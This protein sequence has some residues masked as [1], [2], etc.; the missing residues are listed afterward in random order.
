LLST[1]DSNK[2]KKVQG[3]LVH[4]GL[5]QQHQFATPREAADSVLQDVHDAKYMGELTTTNWKI[6]QVVPLF[7]SM[8]FG[9]TS[10]GYD[11]G[12]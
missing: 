11:Q 12:K 10:A 2:F 4:Q 5:F 6:L 9:C 3:F 7:T 1:W 8:L